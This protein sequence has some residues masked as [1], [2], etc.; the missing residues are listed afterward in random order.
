M[1]EKNV[2]QKLYV[3]FKGRSEIAE[4]FIVKREPTVDFRPKHT[5]CSKLCHMS[6]LSAS[7]NRRPRPT[8]THFYFES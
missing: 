6:A 3:N 8:V 1:T 5:R 4:R 7:L 2:F